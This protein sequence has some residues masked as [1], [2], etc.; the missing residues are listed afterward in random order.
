MT[1][2]PLTSPGSHHP[3]WARRR[4]IDSQQM[5]TCEKAG[6]GYMI[7]CRNS[8]GIIRM[9]GQLLGHTRNCNRT[10]HRLQ[11]TALV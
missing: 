7:I 1:K 4:S 8:R 5:M 3:V 9:V 2:M 10:I 6:A 11:G